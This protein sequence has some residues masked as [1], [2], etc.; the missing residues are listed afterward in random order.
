M[1]AFSIVLIILIA[2]VIAL[3]VA[4]ERRWRAGRL[5][6][7]RGRFVLRMMTGVMLLVLLAGMV[8]GYEVVLAEGFVKARPLF[9][10]SY[11]TTCIVLAFGLVVMALVELRYVARAA[12]KRQESELWRDVASFLAGKGR[13]K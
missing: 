2:G 5:L 3:L 13:G 10:L 11:W 9:F 8:A 7:S 12:R 6:L 1:H 4:E